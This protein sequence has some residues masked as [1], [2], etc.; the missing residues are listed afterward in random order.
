MAQRPRRHQ[1]LGWH[2]PHDN[3]VGVNNSDLPASREAAKPGGSTANASGA[4]I[5]SRVDKYVVI[6]VLHA[7]SEVG[8]TLSFE[9]IETLHAED[10]NSKP[11]A[12][13]TG[14]KVPPAIAGMMVTLD[15]TLRQALGPAGQGFK[16]FAFD[17][18]A[19]HSCEKGRLSI[20]F[21][22]ETYTYETPVP[23][24]PQK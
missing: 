10:G 20:P 18:G 23:G 2:S 16:V 21:A 12:L 24:C 15:G 13:L 7:K 4:R 1:P 3:W 17:G 14:D 22:G 19:V 6:G 9:Q 8:G 5:R 11:L